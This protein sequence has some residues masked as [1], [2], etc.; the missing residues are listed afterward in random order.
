MSSLGNGYRITVST[1]LLK[2]TADQVEELVQK[3][4]GAYENLNAAVNSMSHYWHGKAGETKRSAYYS[5][6][7]SMEDILKRLSTYTS[8]LIQISET[9]EAAEG[10]NLESAE[11]L[12]ADV[13][14]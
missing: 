7:E 3:L 1:E 13:I 8:D 5:R 4:D 10:Q 6:K 14:V 2:N 9:Y 12:S 11:S